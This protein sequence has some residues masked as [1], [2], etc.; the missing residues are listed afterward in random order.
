VLYFQEGLK[1]PGEVKAFTQNYIASQDTVRRWVAECETCPTEEGLTAKQLLESYRQYCACEGEVAQVDTAEA[2]G[3]RLKQ[4][5]FES[6][7]T[8]VGSQYGLKPKV[9]P[10]ILGFEIMTSS[11]QQPAV[12]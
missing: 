2:L 6:R 9:L 12:M 10:D 11:G 4:L 7:R 5:G 3:R 8:R 1:P